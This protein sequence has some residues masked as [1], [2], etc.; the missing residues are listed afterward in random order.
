[1]LAQ[2]LREEGLTQQQIGDRIGGSENKVK[3]YSAV[4]NNV[5]TQVLDLAREYQEGR[6]T[7]KVTNVTFNFTK[8]HK[9]FRNC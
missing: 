3:Q 9:H 8:W 4:L 7:D 6:V 5:V 1:V 2:A